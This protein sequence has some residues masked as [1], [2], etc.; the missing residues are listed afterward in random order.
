M[1]P[2]AFAQVAVTPPKEAERYIKEYFSE[3]PKIKEWQEVQKKHAKRFGWLA[4]ENGRKRWFSGFRNFSEVERAAINMPIQSV[5]ADI[6]KLALIAVHNFIKSECAS[7]ARIVLT[8]HDEL[9]VEVEDAI[10]KETALTAR[11]IMESCYPL[12]V[13]LIVETKRGRALGSMEPLQ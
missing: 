3:F 11:R 4:N 7:R 5:E 6:I 2:R 12:S 8:V 13:P 1:G 9:I 10:L